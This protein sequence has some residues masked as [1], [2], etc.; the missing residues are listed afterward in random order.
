MGFLE[1]SFLL[2]SACAITF[3]LILLGEKI[4]RNLSSRMIN[5]VI[6]L[7]GSLTFTYSVL[8]LI[9]YLLPYNFQMTYFL[10]AGMIIVLN[11]YWFGHFSKSTGEM[12]AFSV[13]GKRLAK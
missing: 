11:R 7:L 8:L 10:L 4:L 2:M 9:T 13:S 6:L 12:K 3:G 5:P 1:F